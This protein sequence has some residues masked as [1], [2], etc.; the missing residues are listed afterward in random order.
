MVVFHLHVSP[1]EFH[2]LLVCSA[3]RVGTAHYMSREQYSGD[4]VTH[5]TDI[6]SLGVTMF[7]ALTG[8]VPFAH[9][10][11]KA[12][13]VM[14]AVCGDSEARNV[15]EVVEASSV[16]D[17]VA[18]VVARAL[19]KE[20]EERFQSAEEMLAAVMDAM[21]RRG[22][23]KYDAMIS[24]RNKSEAAFASGLFAQLSRKQIALGPNGGSRRMRVFL[25]QERLEA[26]ERWDQGF[27]QKGIASSTVMLPLVS[28]GALAGMAELSK[29][30]KIDWLLLEWEVALAL[31]AADRLGKIYPILL[32]KQ[33]SSSGMRTDF[34][35]D[36][37]DCGDD[38]PDSPSR[39]TS[40]EAAKFLKQIDA[41][42]TPQRRTVRDTRDTL[43]RYQ[44]FNLGTQSGT[45]GGSDG[46]G[47]RQMPEDEAIAA[48]VAD[49]TPV[50]EAAVCEA[51]AQ[52]AAVAEPKISAAATGG[53]VQQGSGTPRSPP[54]R[55]ASGTTMKVVM[56]EIKEQMNLE[57]H[58]TL[59]EVVAAA[60]DQF[61]VDTGSGSLKEQ[62]RVVATELGIE[63]GW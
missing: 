43:L 52:A 48:T 18:E 31:E 7:F 32:G 24:Y 13:K 1:L 5:L 25:D 51:M 56:D 19:K 8:Q 36:G 47:G 33:D 46:V 16:G 35:G 14:F 15:Q 54:V 61:G 37:S 21:T 59:K 26:G 49:V 40:D 57:E 30:D 17:K 58:L 27:V 34:F 44:A 42:I 4:D 3:C 53:T 38:V 41:S 63:T 50:V 28:A 62:L 39:L 11:L 12:Q 60:S 20:P 29:A 45:H 9:G 10:E 6:Y 2:P 55:T 22:Y 23:A